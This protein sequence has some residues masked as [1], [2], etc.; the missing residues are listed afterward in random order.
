MINADK[1]TNNVPTNQVFNEKF[2]VLGLK[3]ANIM[4]TKF[5]NK[6]AELNKLRAIAVQEQAYLTK[7]QNELR[8]LWS[9]R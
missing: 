8:R 2:V 7:R 3:T 4:S 1:G 9:N 6:A 5:T